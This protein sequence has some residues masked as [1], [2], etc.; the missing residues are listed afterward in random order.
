MI[1]HPTLGEQ[2]RLLVISYHFPPDVAIGGMRWAGL[3]KYLAQLGWKVWV[4]TAAP[5]AESQDGVTVEVCRPGLTLNDLYRRFRSRHPPAGPP[6]G[7]AGENGAEP[8]PRQPPGLLAKLRAEAAALL[9]FFS[10]GRGWAFRT[11]LRARRLIARVGPHVIVSTSPPVGAHLAAWLATRGSRTRWLVDFRD[12]WAGPV[13]SGWQTHP[14]MRSRLA[15]A[16]TKRL[17]R[18]VVQSASGVITT[19][20]ELALALEARYPHRPVTW[21]RN[22]AD[23]ALLPRRS[24]HPH[25]GLS[26][27]H[28][29]SLYGR[30][31]LTVL[32]RAFRLFLDRHPAA[33]MDGTR[34][35]S[36]GSMDGARTAALEREVA[37]L[38]LGDH[39][40]FQGV[41]PRSA[42][43]DLVA[44]SRLI[45]VPAQNQ[46]LEVPGK[47]YEALAVGV[48]TVVIAS[49][50]TAPGREAM[51]LGVALVEP[52][53]VNAMLDVLEAVWRNEEGGCGTAQRAIDYRELA[54]SVSGILADS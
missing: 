38:S 14:Y 23:G 8:T 21:V 5:G 47:L 39:V 32:L 11:A 37:A 40:E 7:S 19:T 1:A 36:A 52:S 12:P 18:L 28:V 24:D 41:V 44:R 27:A 50:D 2:P 25:P 46:E 26:I 33:A 48:P 20:S 43:L 3:T 10:E 35:R 30:R 53:D 13:S 51:R 15:W 9:L 22:G 54:V 16:L 31:D 17:E 29:G 49:G 45:V 6:P 34:L 4:L 42:A